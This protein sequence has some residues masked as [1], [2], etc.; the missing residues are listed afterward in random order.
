MLVLKA[1]MRM[2]ELSDVLTMIVLRHFRLNGFV[3][4]THLIGK[5]QTGSIKHQ[6]VFGVEVSQSDSKRGGDIQ[7]NLAPT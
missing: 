2:D 1:L 6:V 4:D 5:F 3:V 7:G